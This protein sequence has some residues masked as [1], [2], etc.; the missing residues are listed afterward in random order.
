MDYLGNSEAD[1]A[2]EFFAFFGAGL[3]K[4]HLPV[5]CGTTGLLCCRYRATL[6]P[7]S[8]EDLS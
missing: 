7:P 4:N 5:N 2:D 8:S 6:S 1:N 3:S